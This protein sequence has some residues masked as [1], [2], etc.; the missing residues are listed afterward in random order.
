MTES[1]SFNLRDENGVWI[2]TCRA[3]GFVITKPS[4]EAAIQEALAR[5]VR[6]L[7]T[8][9]VYPK[10]QPRVSRTEV[11]QKQAPRK[12]GGKTVRDMSPDKTV[13]A[14]VEA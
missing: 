4:E 11:F 13:F 1:F 8:I 10:T 14:T 12:F 6:H 5:W 7:R 3:P 2:A 9:S